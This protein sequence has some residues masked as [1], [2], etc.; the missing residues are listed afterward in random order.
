MRSPPRTL[1]PRLGTGI[2]RHRVL[3][4]GLAVRGHRTALAGRPPAGAE[5]GAQIHQPLAVV[6][7]AICGQARF[8][9]GPEL[10]LH[11]G[12]AGP[13]GNCGMPR[14]DAAHIA[15][16]DRVTITESLRQDGAGRGPAN[17]R[18]RHYRCQ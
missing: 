2:A 4:P 17:A 8:S 6:G 18:Q 11:S 10:P 12:F 7:K 13:T 3:D 1:P 14:K 15:V 5:G 16:E 9:Q